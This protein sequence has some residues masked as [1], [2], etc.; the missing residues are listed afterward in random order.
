M[1]IIQLL[2]LPIATKEQ[3]KLI[4]QAKSTACLLQALAIVR[5]EIA[6]AWQAL[7]SLTVL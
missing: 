6:A 3:P 1:T 2:Q 5:L 4:F 7:Q